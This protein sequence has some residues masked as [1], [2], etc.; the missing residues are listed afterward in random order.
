MTKKGIID[1]VAGL[2]F[3]TTIYFPIEKVSNLLNLLQQQ[4]S[5]NWR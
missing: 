3:I 2:K 5:S 4:T 1:E